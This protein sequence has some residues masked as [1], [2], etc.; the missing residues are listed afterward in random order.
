MNALS[1]DRY[2]L[3]VPTD[4][5]TAVTKLMSGICSLK[6][7]VESFYKYMCTLASHEMSPL[8]V[9]PSALRKI[10]LDV[11]L[12]FTHTIDWLYLMTQM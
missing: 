3:S 8:T 1:D 7:D 9:P 6:E 2:V 4:I 12:R 5:C 11:K 10:L